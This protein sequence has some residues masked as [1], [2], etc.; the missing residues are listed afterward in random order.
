MR[1]TRMRTGDKR[2]QTLDLVCEPVFHEEI[3]GPVGHGWLRPEPR[4]PQ[5]IKYCIGAKCAVFL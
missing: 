1:S 4:I 2:V 3:Q 5:P